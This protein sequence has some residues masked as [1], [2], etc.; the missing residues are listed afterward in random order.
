MEVLLVLPMH[1]ILHSS[2]LLLQ[3]VVSVHFKNA[4]LFGNGKG[5]LQ[6]LADLRLC[7]RDWAEL[8]ARAEFLHRTPPPG[9]TPVPCFHRASPDTFPSLSPLPPSPLHT[10]MHLPE[11]L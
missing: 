6:G 7:A 11:L 8:W 1:P 2:S 10:P 5:F 9:G 3:Y 4:P